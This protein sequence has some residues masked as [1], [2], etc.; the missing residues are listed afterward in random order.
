MVYTLPLQFHF[1][2]FEF[3]GGMNLYS[4]DYARRSGGRGIVGKSRRVAGA[5]DNLGGFLSTRAT[6]PWGIV[7][8][9]AYRRDRFASREHQHDLREICDTRFIP[10]TTL[11]P[12]TTLVDIGGGV[13]VPVTVSIPITIDVPVQTNCRNERLV[14]NV[15][16]QTWFNDAFEAGLLTEPFEDVKVWLKYAR[17]FRNPNVDELILKSTS[18]APQTGKHWDLGVR[19]SFSNR[20]HAALSLFDICIEKE[21]RFGFDPD[22]GLINNHN[23]A[24]PTT[25]RGLELELRG[26]PTPRLSWWSNLGYLD[27][28]ID[29]PT[30]NDI[31]IPLV[32][33]VTANFGFAWQVFRGGEIVL[34]AKHV[35]SRS[36]GNDSGTRQFD[37][38]NAY[39][40]IDAKLR[41][42]LPHCEFHLGIGNLLDEIYGTT[43]FANTRYPL[44]GRTF[45]AG[46]SLRI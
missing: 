29:F 5:L 32:P 3:S 43:G 13:F 11:V 33:A 18:L 6:L 46:L 16:K 2:Q 38:L 35:G 7:A 23:L 31:D 34:T 9:V 22:T 30:R 14:T 4:A 39:Q 28:A 21:I 1:A 37:A 19:I 41:Y 15:A 20:L 40:L 24:T 36:D 27:T 12:Q 44:P 17:S 45:Y 42:A 26:T 10:R 25:R 8:E